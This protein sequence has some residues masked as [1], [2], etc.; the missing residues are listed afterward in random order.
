MSHSKNNV[1]L[2]GG[3]S[4]FA[5]IGITDMTDVIRHRLIKLFHS[6][7]TVYYILHVTFHSL[8]SSSEAFIRLKEI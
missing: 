8:A 2:I 4:L 1:H 6:T 3:S 5:F 7:F